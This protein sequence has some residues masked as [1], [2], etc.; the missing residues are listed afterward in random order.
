MNNL[1]ISK[2]INDGV[3]EGKSYEEINKELKEAGSNLVLSDEKHGN[4]IIEIGVGSPEPVTV[5]NGKLTEPVG[6]PYQDIVYYN[7]KAYY[8]DNDKVTLVEKKNEEKEVPVWAVPWD[9]ELDKYKPDP[10]MMYRPE[11]ANQVV[12]KGKL[13]Y[14]Y[15]ANGNAEYEP[16]SMRDYDKDHNRNQ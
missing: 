6:V 9:E 13:R 3:N 16:V 1:E 8:L 5:K 12:T 4:A 7:G 14:R 2:I 15:D 11:Y 10:D